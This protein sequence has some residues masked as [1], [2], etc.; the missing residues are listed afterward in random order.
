MS[1]QA[2][3]PLDQAEARALTDAGY[4]DVAEYVRLAHER[5]WTA[6]PQLDRTAEGWARG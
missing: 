5:G 4:M 2:P 3:R 1:P 6:T